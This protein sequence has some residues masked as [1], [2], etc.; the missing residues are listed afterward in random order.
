MNLR[1]FFN[2]S[3]TLGVVCILFVELSVGNLEDSKDLLRCVIDEDA[4]IEG[5]S[6]N[7]YPIEDFG[8]TQ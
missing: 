6:T 7:S 5:S 4:M 1:R 2:E 8:Y 3:H